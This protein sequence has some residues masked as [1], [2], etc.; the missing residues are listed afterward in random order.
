MFAFT[1]QSM[2]SLIC[3]LDFEKPNQMKIDEL[4]QRGELREL[5]SKVLRRR[6]RKDFKSGF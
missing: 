3:L 1:F 4:L 5:C 2:F 6:I